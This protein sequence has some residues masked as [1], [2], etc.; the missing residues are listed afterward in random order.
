MAAAWVDQAKIHG[1]GVL[2]LAAERELMAAARVG[3]P[4]TKA[5]M[6]AIDRAYART[7]QA[8]PHLFRD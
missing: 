5:R 8:F 3:G 7:S 2:P 6:R 1:C 4:D